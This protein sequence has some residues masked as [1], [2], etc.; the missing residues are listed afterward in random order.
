M[1]LNPLDDRIVIKQSE[2]EEKTSGGIILP[3]TAKEKPQQGLVRACRMLF[4]QACAVRVFHDQDQVG[5]PPAP[6]LETTAG[7]PQR[8]IGAGPAGEGEAY[9]GEHL[10]QPVARILDEGDAGAWKEALG[11]DGVGEKGRILAQI[12]GGDA[13]EAHFLFA[14]RA[15]QRCL[16]RAAPDDRGPQPRDD[17]RRFGSR[18][19][20]GFGAEIGPSLQARER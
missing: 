10:G 14:L 11:L 5:L 17:R 4:D 6:A 12:S 3:D 16:E 2:A 18:P 9:K 20:V 1:K 19:A 7:P 13:G 15:D 8:L